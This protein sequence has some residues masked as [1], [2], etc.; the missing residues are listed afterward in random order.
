[1]VSIK[2]TRRKA[3]TV[4]AATGLV[5]LI[6]G[7]APAAA[8]NVATG[9][10]ASAAGGPAAKQPQSSTA[11]PGGYK[12]VSAG[13]SVAAGTEASGSVTCPATSGGATRRPQ[14]GGV[15]ITS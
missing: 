13:F 10:P 9:A 3:G 14:S 6:I 4:V 2:W 12:I 8:K 5:A 15:V 11:V 7:S 1:M